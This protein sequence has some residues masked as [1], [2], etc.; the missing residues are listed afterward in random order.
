MSTAY[1]PLAFSTLT[2]SKFLSSSLQVFAK[3]FLC[4]SGAQTPEI[5]G[6]LLVL[7]LVGFLMRRPVRLCVVVALQSRCMVPSALYIRS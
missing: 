7:R 2:G 6:D 5:I 3:Q 4:E 1:D